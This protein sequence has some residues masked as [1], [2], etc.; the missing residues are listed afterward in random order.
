MK[1][2]CSLLVTLLGVLQL[3]GVATAQVPDAGSVETL[4]SEQISGEEL[5]LPGTASFEPLTPAQIDIFFDSLRAG[6]QFRLPPLRTT[7]QVDSNIS[8]IWAGS[9]FSVESEFEEIVLRFRPTTEARVARQS[10]GA[11]KVPLADSVDVEIHRSAKGIVIQHALAVEASARTGMLAKLDPFKTHPTRT[12]FV[13]AARDAGMY[14]SVPPLTSGQAEQG[15]PVLVCP[16][17]YQ[18]AQSARGANASMQLLP[19]PYELTEVKVV[20]SGRS[21]ASISTGLSKERLALAIAPTAELPPTTEGRD[22]VVALSPDLTLVY[23]PTA[24]FD[25]FRFVPRSSIQA[26]LLLMAEMQNKAGYIRRQYYSN[27][28]YIQ[29]LNQPSPISVVLDGLRAAT[30]TGACYL[31]LVQRTRWSEYDKRVA[32]F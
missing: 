21:R 25:F 23:R 19:S 1:R 13:K 11:T 28:L 2:Y 29:K 27:T 8:G 14:F 24:P 18:I 3:I 15:W 17:T 22:E 31:L 30:D 5:S 20:V 9:T 16:R 6:S 7:Q 32:A 4:G 26:G 10:E 12:A